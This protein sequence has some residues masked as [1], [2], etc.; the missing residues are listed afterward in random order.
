MCNNKSIKIKALENN[1]TVLSLHNQL[2]NGSTATAT[3]TASTTTLY[4][5]FLGE[6]SLEKNFKMLFRGEVVGGASKFHN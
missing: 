2:A 4:D 6:K 5:C 1:K 3:A